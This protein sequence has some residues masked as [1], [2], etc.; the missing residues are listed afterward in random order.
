ME[1]QRGEVTCSESQVRLSRWKNASGQ[2]FQPGVW[3]RGNGE[4]VWGS[5]LLQV[6]AQSQLY[7][8]NGGQDG[9]QAQGWSIRVQASGS[10]PGD[11]CGS[12][13]SHFWWS[14]LRAGLLLSAWRQSPRGAGGRPSA[15]E[16]PTTK[17]DPAQN[18]S[19]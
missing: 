4:H 15:Q 12:V 19:S 13:W 2:A 17:D 18:V 7:L 6:W 9:G 3:E 16:A 11:A 10:P 1:A 8:G 5:Q 14:H